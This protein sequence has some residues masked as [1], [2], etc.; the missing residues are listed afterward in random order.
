MAA[1]KPDVCLYHFPCDD[2]FAAAWVVRQRWPDCRLEPTNYGLP[3]PDGLA[4]KNI[5]MVD[6]SLKRDAMLELAR[7]ARSVVV[8]DHHA[9]AQDEL[10]DFTVGWNPIHPDAPEFT[11]WQVMLDDPRTDPTH[12][13][14]AHFDMSRSGAQLAWGFIRPFLPPPLIVN[15]VADRDLWRFAIPNSRKFSLFLRSHPYDFD[16]WTD[17]ADRLNADLTGDGVLAEAAAIERYH[18]ARIAELVPTAT[19]QRIGEWAGVPVAHAPYTFASDLGHALLKA[20]PDAPFA[21]V[22]VDAYGA[23][24]FSLRSENSREDVSKV[25]RAFGG[26]GHRNAAGF[27]VPVV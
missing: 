18:D 19:L 14:L 13:V 25:A 4:G 16:V 15:F 8:L 23:R 9:S 10:R 3:L 17:I 21:A 1:W 6:F 5:L 26:G 12:R 20:H 24:T 27:R 2:G 7:Y 22:V 11:G